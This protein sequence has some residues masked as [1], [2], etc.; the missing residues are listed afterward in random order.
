VF[1]AP[2]PAAAQIEGNSRISRRLT[3]IRRRVHVRTRAQIT[4]IGGLNPRSRARGLVLLPRV[5]VD[6]RRMPA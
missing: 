4:V 3:G 2:D 6:R 1:D 5:Y